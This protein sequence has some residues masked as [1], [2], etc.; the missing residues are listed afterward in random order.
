MGGSKKDNK[1]R[2]LPALS[3]PRVHL[4]MFRSLNGV[5][6]VEVPGPV[7]AGLTYT[8]TGVRAGL[9]LSQVVVLLETVLLNWNINIL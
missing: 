1:R 2:F 5:N 4:S 7:T 8:R 3:V 9:R 6:T